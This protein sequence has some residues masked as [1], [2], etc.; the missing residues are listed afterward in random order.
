MYLSDRVPGLRGDTPELRPDAAEQPGLRPVDHGERGEA[1]EVPQLQR[2]APASAPRELLDDA[3]LH[4]RAGPRL[5]F[6]PLS[7]ST[8]TRS[9]GFR[10]T[11]VARY[12]DLLFSNLSSQ[13]QLGIALPY[14]GFT[15]TVQQAL[16]PYPQFTG[17][18]FLNN[19][20]G[21]T[22]YNSL[23]TTLERHFSKG[24]ALVAAYTL[25]KTEDN[26]L[27]Q[28]ASGEEWGLAGGSRHFP[29]F[30]KLTWIYELPIGPGK[31]ID[32]DGVL[33]HIVGG[34]TLTG[35]HNYR[36]GGTLSVFDSRINRVGT[37]FPFRPDVVEGVDPIIFDGSHVD[38]VRGTPYLNP[39]AFATQPLSA[40]G[41]PSRPGTAPPVL[42]DARG[43]AFFSED[44]G[45]MKRF[46]AGGDR[47]FEFRVDLI[48]AL[49]RS[50]VGGP[51]TDISSPNFGRI[52]GV[53][54]G[55]RRLQLSLRATF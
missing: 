53:G 34:W 20:R 10:S 49:N 45:L 50:G 5:P 17:I 32:V 8:A 38:L 2:H 36:S 3:R 47:S 16:R 14:P 19:F 12:G 39:A 37:G 52:F 33:G 11:H 28:D 4:R 51:N 30:L 42:L 6:D 7:P 55:A 27:K 48:N 26:Y 18:T 35:I 43:P 23:Q 21:K 40:Q 15:G 9:T 46:A 25:S 13:P 41:V 54:I 24:L 22:R 1:R 29:H 44:I 31:A